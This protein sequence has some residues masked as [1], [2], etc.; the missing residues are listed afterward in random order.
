MKK[1]LTFDDVLITPLFSEKENRTD[2]YVNPGVNYLGIPLTKPIIASNMDTICSSEMAAAMALNGAVG[3]LH[4]FNTIEENIK[5]YYAAKDLIYNNVSYNSSVHSSAIIGSVGIGDVEYERAIALTKAGCKHILIDVAHGAATHVVRQY[6]RIRRVL[7][8][9]V[10]IIVGNFA[11]ADSIK[12]FNERCQSSRKADSFKLGIGGGS[13][14]STR[15][16]TGCGWPTL[17]SVLDCKD[18]T[19]PLIADGGIKTSGDIAKSLVAGVSVVMVGSLLAGTDE[20]PGELVDSFG[21]PWNGDSD[22]HS[23]SPTDKKFK[24]YRGSAS[25]ESYAAQGKTA[26]HRAPEGVSRLVECKGP[27]ANVLN[28]LTGGLRSSMTYL[29]AGTLAELRECELVEISTNGHKESTPHG[30]QW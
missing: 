20:T 15:I 13:N 21:R 18:I 1:L 14:C 17:A 9:S 6:D 30:L 29:N 23:Y 12:L 2:E 19:A 28:T 16:V 24:K 7:D 4:R 8:D 3:A 10:Y 25:A 22:H 26:K 11:T 27:V 5:E